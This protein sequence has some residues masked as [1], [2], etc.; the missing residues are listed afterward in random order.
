VIPLFA[1]HATQPNNREHK[2]LPVVESL[3]ADII[4]R[5]FVHI[6]C[7]QP[8]E[9]IFQYSKGENAFPAGHYLMRFSRFLIE[10]TLQPGFDFRI[11]YLRWKSMAKRQNDMI[12]DARAEIFKHW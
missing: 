5:R 6:G 3:A 9:L 8:A 1:V 4:P 12:F 11:G 7:Q 10:H 2:N